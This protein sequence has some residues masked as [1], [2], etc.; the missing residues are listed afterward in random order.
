MLRKPQAYK[1]DNIRDGPKRKGISAL[2]NSNKPLV[3]QKR[4]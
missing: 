3:L 4:A 1:D 2:A